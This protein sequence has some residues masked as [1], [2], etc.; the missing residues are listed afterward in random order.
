MDPA[1]IRQAT[2][3]EITDL[4]ND[5][6][7]PVRSGVALALASI[8]P[9]A[10]R[11]IPALKEALERAKDH[12]SQIQNRNFTKNGLDFFLGPTSANNICYAFQTIGGSSPDCFDGH[13]E[14]PPKR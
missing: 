12:M 6:S 13:F 9:P 10:Q 11:A 5:D 8:G 2:I 1:Q 3:D 7:D 4:L 14:E